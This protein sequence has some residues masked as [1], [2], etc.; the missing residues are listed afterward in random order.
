M[1]DLTDLEPKLQPD[2]GFDDTNCSTTQNEMPPDESSGDT[3]F[4]TKTQKMPP[5]DN[6][7]AEETGG[8][9]FERLD[10]KSHVQTTEGDPQQARHT[11][12]P[13]REYVP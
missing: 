8:A 12:S 10:D 9:G 3:N 2:K 4:N 5:D 13:S 7:L 6:L 1:D 11:A